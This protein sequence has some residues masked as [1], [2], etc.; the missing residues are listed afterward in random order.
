MLFMEDKFDYENFKTELQG[1]SEEVNHQVSYT[2]LLMLE[3]L[4]DEFGISVKLNEDML[5]EW[6]RIVSD[7]SKFIIKSAIS[8]GVDNIG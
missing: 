4:D 2:M 7:M 3:M 5:P 6:N 8:Q 1:F